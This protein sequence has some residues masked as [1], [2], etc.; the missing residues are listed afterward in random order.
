MSQ[1][2]LETLILYRTLKRESI[3]EMMNY[4]KR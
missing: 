4:S 3:I 2:L 1:I